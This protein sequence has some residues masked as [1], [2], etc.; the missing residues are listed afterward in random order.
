M[1]KYIIGSVLKYPKKDP[2]HIRETTG[3]KVLNSNIPSEWMI[4]DATEREY[5]IDC[6]VELDDKKCST[7]NCLLVMKTNNRL[8][9]GRR[10]RDDWTIMPLNPLPY[11]QRVGERSKEC[12]AYKME[13]DQQCKHHQ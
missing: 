1:K 8:T 13:V 7:A 3:Y 10:A 2:N 5:G 9:T 12:E 11:K 6:Y 4:R